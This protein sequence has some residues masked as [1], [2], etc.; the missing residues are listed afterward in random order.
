MTMQVSVRR[1]SAMMAELISR[2]SPDLPWAWSASTEALTRNQVHTI[3]WASAAASASGCG[4]RAAGALGSAGAADVAGDGE[5]AGVERARTWVRVGEYI[6]VRL[7]MGG[8]SWLK[9]E[10]GKR[11]EWRG[12]RGRPL[13][14]PCLIVSDLG[15][16]S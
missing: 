7:R 15:A 3:C 12:R 1:L 9:M 8:A 10:S 13:I 4:E 5:P 2:M 16:K 11:R 14:Q 6:G